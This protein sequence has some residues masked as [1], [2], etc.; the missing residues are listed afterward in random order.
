MSVTRPLTS[1]K[2]TR[3]PILIGCEIASCTPATMLASVCWAAKPTIAAS[4]AVEARIPVARR[5]SSV[6]W[7]RARA[8]R[9]RKRMS[10]K[11]RRRKRRR[12]LVDR[13]TCETAGVMVLNLAAG[14]HP[15]PFP[16]SNWG[17]RAGVLGVLLALGTG[18]VLGIPAVVID[19]PANGDLSTAAN[20]VVQLA[21]ALG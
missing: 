14:E 9:I 3:S 20:V 16:Y 13:E 11:R 4:T 7:L 2:A 17:P 18:L 6:N 21:T 5:F 1:S 8:T 19:N 15:T 10:R 12:V